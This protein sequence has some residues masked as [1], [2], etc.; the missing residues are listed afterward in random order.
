MIRD[1][2]GDLH[3]ANVFFHPHPI[4]F[5]CIEFND[6]YRE[7]DQLEEIA[8]LYVDL[9]RLN[10]RDLAR[11]FMVHYKEQNPG[12]FEETDELL[13]DYY[14]AYR[15]SVRSKVMLISILQSGLSDKSIEKTK[16]DL[17]KFL[18]VYL[19]YQKKWL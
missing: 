12:V 9:L 6:R 2:H 16:K 1:L 7:I 11:D 17:E 10:A 13:F 15:S 4:V 19:M 8:T 18:S 3:A 14:C 5:D